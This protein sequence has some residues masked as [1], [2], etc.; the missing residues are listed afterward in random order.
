MCV[1]AAAACR[2]QPVEREAY[3]DTLAP[4]P[5]P[6]I[7]EVS[8]PGHHG[9][10]FV[11]A[12]A[13][14]PSTFNPL[15]SNSV[16]TD[17]V[18]NRLFTSL[19]LFDTEAQQTRP[20]LATSWDEAADGTTWTFHLRRGAV[21]SD[22]RPITADDVVFT[23]QATYTAAFQPSWRDI[24]SM[25]GTPWTVTAVDATTVLIRTP[26]PNAIVPDLL[27]D[28]YILPR[29]TLASRLADGSLGSAYGLSTPPESLVSSG[30]W[31]LHKYIAGDRVVLRRNPHWFGTD[32]TGQRLPYLN[33]LVFLIT[34]D[35]DA[36]DLKLRAGEVDGLPSQVLKA[37]NYAWYEQHQQDG[38][39]TL[40]TLGPALN[41]THLWFNLAM[42]RTATGGM[43][44]EPAAGR[45]KYAW[46]NNP[47]FRLAVAHAIDQ[48]GMIRSVF[49]GNAVRT[50]S[51]L[52]PGNVRWHQPDLPQ[53]DFNPAEARRLLAG[54]GWKDADGDGVLE[55]TAGHSVRFTLQV[56]SNNR[57]RLAMAN[58][59]RDDLAKIGLGVT[60]V[61]LEFNTTQQH[62]VQ[63]FDY[64]AAIGGLGAA[65]PP[66]PAIAMNVFRSSGTNHRWHPRQPLP[67][68]PDDARIDR[69]MNALL[70]TADPAARLR[71]WRD[72]VRTINDSALI[73]WLPSPIVKTPIRSGFANVR[74]S[75]FDNIVTRNIE[76][77]YATPPRP[78]P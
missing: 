3:R 24:L 27:A 54:L 76:A 19:T 55:D 26:K 46:F 65:L 69:M 32:Q 43:T 63:T 67:G 14:A 10:R 68:T 71:A 31:M 22:G 74:P 59:I 49:S 35:Q 5:E 20:A 34:P 70:E 40:H 29:H 9:G 50:S 39:F 41:S 17:D 36:A 25:D 21:F 8:P 51:L 56:S 66:D 33:E 57:I 37:D 6:L 38:G 60:L 11:V 77:A 13:A 62:F 78:A 44:G 18:L 12:S 42:A 2:R 61:P 28:F 58:F 23:F 48:D 53:S 16:Y 45:V 4:P 52:T 72:V 64:D 30:A 1:M 15:V 47:A 7:T 75:P 73:V